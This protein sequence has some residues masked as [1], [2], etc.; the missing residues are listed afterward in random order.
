[1]RPHRATGPRTAPWL[2]HSPRWARVFPANFQ[3]SCSEAA[4]RSFPGTQ[5]VPQ[6]PQSPRPLLLT[7]AHAP[8]PLPPPPAVT[9][10]SLLP[11]TS[12]PEAPGLSK[13]LAPIA[14]PPLPTQLRPTQCLAPSPRPPEHYSPLP[15]GLT[16][17]KGIY[18]PP[19]SQP[20]PSQT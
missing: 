20:I 15:P 16:P 12:V 5:G 18:C 3:C 9:T 2:V 17:E 14:S 8:S 1:M 11:V 10:C 7:L 4:L 6:L 19:P 13:A